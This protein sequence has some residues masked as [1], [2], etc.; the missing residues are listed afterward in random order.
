[1]ALY[2][3]ANEYPGL[4]RNVKTEDG[5]AFLVVN[6]EDRHNDILE[7]VQSLKRLLDDANTIA[8]A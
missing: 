4:S 6:S 7:M 2:Q 5:T 1:M 8:D 3:R